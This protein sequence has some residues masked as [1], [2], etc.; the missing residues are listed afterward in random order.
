MRV[1]QECLC[2]FYNEVPRPLAS[3]SDVSNFPPR[4]RCR[5]SS[6]PGNRLPIAP[7][8]RGPTPELRAI[9]WLGHGDQSL[10]LNSGSLD[11]ARC[12]REVSLDNVR[13]LLRRITVDHKAKIRQSGPDVWRTE[14]DKRLMI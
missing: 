8:E 6:S 12:P 3:V 7:T 11:K 13:E 1:A 4:V 9:Y 5:C 10:R 14:R 2:D